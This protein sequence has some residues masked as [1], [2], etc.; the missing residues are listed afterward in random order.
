MVFLPFHRQQCSALSFLALLALSETNTPQQCGE[1]A[2]HLCAIAVKKC[3]CLPARYTIRRATGAR[4]P[5][6][7]TAPT[8]LLAP[9]AFEENR[10]ECGPVALV[11]AG[12]VPGCWDRV[13]PA[14]PHALQG[15]VVTATLHSITCWLTH[16]GGID[17]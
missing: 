3:K 12:S 7:P 11:P 1:Q 15:V 2:L 14:S 6:S 10:N 5:G 13:D 8:P 17:F 9:D 4:L 16:S